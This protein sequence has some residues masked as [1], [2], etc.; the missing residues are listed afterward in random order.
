MALVTALFFSVTSNQINYCFPRYN[1]VIVT[2][3]KM[4]RVTK[5]DLT[6]VIFSRVCSL[7]QPNTV[8]L[9]CVL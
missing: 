4:R 1:A 5:I 3:I 7:S 6:V 8:F 9:L 2:D